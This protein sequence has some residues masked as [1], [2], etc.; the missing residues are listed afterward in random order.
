MNCCHILAEK[1]NTEMAQYL[2]EMARNTDT[3]STLLMEVCKLRSLA[4]IHIAAFKGHVQFVELLL[5]NGVDVNIRSYSDLTP[6]M[7]A[8]LGQHVD[9]VHLLCSRCTPIGF[10]HERCRVNFSYTTPLVVA[11][12]LGLVDIVEVLI[13]KKANANDTVDSGMTALHRA[14]WNGHEKVVTLLL[15]TGN[16]L[17]NQADDDGDTALMFASMGNHLNTMKVLIDHGASLY[18]QNKLGETVWFYVAS[19]D[20]DAFVEEFTALLG[21]VPHNQG[22]KAGNTPLHVAAI[23]GNTRVTEHLLKKADI[24]LR[25]K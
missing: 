12:Q 25:N 8:I 2:L 22:N 18:D 13:D 3:R 15:T 23:H 16:A 6:M 24:A 4:P 5:D 21:I 9:M 14:A 17:V 11:S 1:G 20:N 19:S 7:C 10:A